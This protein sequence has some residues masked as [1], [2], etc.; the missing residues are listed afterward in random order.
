MNQNIQKQC[1]KLDD[2]LQSFETPNPD[3]AIKTEPK[4]TD[5][6]V[7]PSN[8]P[9]KPLPLVEI[10]LDFA[11]SNMEYKI[12]RSL[13]LRNL[14]Q[15]KESFGSQ[16]IF[17]NGK[18]IWEKET[19]K[20]IDEEKVETVSNVLSPESP[21]KTMKDSPEKTGLDSQITH[22]NSDEQIQKNAIE[23][24]SASTS[25][26]IDTK[27]SNIKQSHKEAKITDSESN[28]S[29]DRLMLR[30]VRRNIDTSSLT[31]KLDATDSTESSTENNQSL[32][33]PKKTPVSLNTKSQ[34]L[35]LKKGK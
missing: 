35:S 9:V 34:T 25:D 24:S 11:I 2:L 12:Q 28:T 18:I 19:E 20:E 10:D 29:H 5:S 27:L 4:P 26:I 1:S 16:M 23:E 15:L 33:W 7:L 8:C 32:K 30:S 3:D 13:W 22:T 14:L 31:I 21:D 17:Y 6:H